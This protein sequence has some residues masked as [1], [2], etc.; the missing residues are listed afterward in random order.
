M[1]NR[2]RETPAE[3][4]PAVEPEEAIR[5][6]ES[7][8]RG[9]ASAVDAA[10]ENDEARADHSQRNNWMAMVLGADVLG[11]PIVRRQIPLLL[12]CLLY[13]LLIVGNRYRV[14]S[15]SRERNA[16]AERVERLREHR[17]MLQ[18]QYQQSVRIS[19]IAEDLK[20]TGV[21]ITAGPP[22]EI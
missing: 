14:E 19:Q 8:E 17:I 2:F 11:S 22:Y 18:E 9:Q 13:L 3:Q 15:L 21:G 16:S 7:V 5:E 20:E 1:A 4:Q 6:E 12:L 10:P